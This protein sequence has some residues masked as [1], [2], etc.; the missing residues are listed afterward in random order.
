MGN[1]FP[2]AWPVVNVGEIRKETARFCT[3]TPYV[4]HF[5]HLQLVRRV[6]GAVLD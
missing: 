6:G 2:G 4:P 5:I 1:D 3:N